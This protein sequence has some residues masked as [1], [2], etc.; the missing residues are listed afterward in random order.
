MSDNPKF[1]HDYG[2]A[3]GCLGAIDERFTMYF[4]D[5][6]EAPLYFCSACGKRAEQ[7]TAAINNAFATRTGFAEEFKSAIDKAESERKVQ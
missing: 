7:I 2:D 3:P 5:I 1:C 4:D 6:G